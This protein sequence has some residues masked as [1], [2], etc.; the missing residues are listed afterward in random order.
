M[1]E[2][3]DLIESIEIGNRSIKD[4]TVLQEVVELKKML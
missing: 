3:I 4:E 1:K 2:A